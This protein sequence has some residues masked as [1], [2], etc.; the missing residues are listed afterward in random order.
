VERITQTEIATRLVPSGTCSTF[1]TASAASDRTAQSWNWALHA[2]LETAPRTNAELGKQ[3]R[4]SP[5]GK[6]NEVGPAHIADTSGRYSGL[7]SKR[8]MQES[9]QACPVTI[10]R[11]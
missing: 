11:R 6:S 3:A 4:R 10:G 9:E 1:V 5:T 8:L 2:K 7:D